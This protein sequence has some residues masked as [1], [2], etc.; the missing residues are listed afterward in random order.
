M[1]KIC[2]LIKNRVKRFLN[3]AF[4]AFCEFNDSW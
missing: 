2:N 1:K 3:A 4:K